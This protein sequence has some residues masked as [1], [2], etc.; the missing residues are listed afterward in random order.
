MW[1]SFLIDNIPNMAYIYGMLIQRAI[2]IS[3]NSSFLLF[4]AR[5]TGKSTYLTTQ[6]AEDFALTLNLLIPAEFQRYLLTPE[7]LSDQIEQ[8]KRKKQTSDL[9]IF[10]DEI[11]RVPELL[12]IVHYH[13]E[14]DK[15]KFAISGSS[16][17]KLKRGATNLLA[18]RAFTYNL[19]PLTVSELGETFSLEDVLQFGS[20]PRLLEL[21]DLEDKKLYLE[22][23]AQT[24]L[25]EEIWNEHIV[26]ALPP[27]QKFLSVASQM[28]GEIINFSK[29]ADDVGIDSKSVKSY[30]QILEDTLIGFFLEPFHRSVR[31]RQR[32]S[33]KFYFFD[34]GV[35]RSLDKSIGARL[36]PGSS[37]YGRAFEHFFIVELLREN[38]YQR[39][40]CSFY[41]LRTKENAEIDLIIER[42]GMPT[43]IVE[44]KSTN[45][46]TNRHLSSL[47]AFKPD[48]PKCRALCI[49]L[50]KKARVVDGIEILHWR[51]GLAEILS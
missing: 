13:I 39:K 11:Q 40:G 5:G 7:L 26:R 38:N 28:N 6:F 32:E 43:F 45:L 44:I 41:Y 9:W 49:S 37:E 18:G 10:I 24:Y 33:P 1:V 36:I 17:R 47:K 25:Q 4:G 27:F 21:T 12:N 3:K 2:N 42:V 35:K 50:D 46:V 8:V 16:A 51:D 48:F 20:L 15:I 29:I 14:K 22:S 30:F 34:L 31:K 19:F 23:Y